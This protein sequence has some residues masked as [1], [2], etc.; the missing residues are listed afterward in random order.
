MRPI[1]RAWLRRAVQVIVPGLLLLVIVLAACDKLIRDSAE[2]YMFGRLEEVPMNEVGLVLGTSHRARGGGGNPYFNHRIAAAS[3]LW[4]AGRVR[5]LLLSGDN[6]TLSYNEPREM[7]RALIANGVDST[8][9]VLD[10]AGFRTL[11]S[12]VRAK[13]VFGQQRF[14]IISQRFHNERAVYLARH[15]GIEAVAFNAGEPP[16]RYG[17]R[18]WLRERFARAKVFVDLLFG[19]SPKFLGERV[20]LP[21]PAEAVPD[22]LK[23]ERSAE[24]SVGEAGSLQR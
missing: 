13:E 23:R 3:A 19:V 9:I 10:F 21:A 4:H 18:V 8:R 2:P 6:G 11:D 24:A 12:V 16:P 17:L 5:Y 22:S 20:P 1:K 7:R 14:T 15:L